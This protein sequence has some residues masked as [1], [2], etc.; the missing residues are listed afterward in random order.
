MYSQIRTNIIK[1]SI[2]L[3]AIYRFNEI[4]NYNPHDYFHRNRIYNPKIYLESQKTQIAKTILRKNKAGSITHPYFQ[5][6]QEHIVIKTVWYWYKNRVI[7][8]Q[9]RI[10]YPE[11]NP[12][13]Y[14]QLIYD[15]EGKNIKWGKDSFFN[16]QC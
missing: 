16:Y 1:M 15:K 14:G 8:Q 2:L 9:N 12:C 10:E 5:L 7:N 6:Y 13:I 4:P 3:K 11:I